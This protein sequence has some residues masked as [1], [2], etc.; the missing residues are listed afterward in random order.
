MEER[1]HTVKRDDAVVVE[2]GL[3]DQIAQ[4]R[5]AGVQAELAHDQAKLGRGDVAWEGAPQVRNTSG[6]GSGQFTHHR[7][8][9]PAGG[10]QPQAT[11]LAGDSTPL[12]AIG[13]ALSGTLAPR[14]C[15]QLAV[16]ACRD[17][18]SWSRDAENAEKTGRTKISNTSLYR[19]IWSGVSADLAS[20]EACRHSPDR[21]APSAL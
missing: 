19:A 5:V 12:A 9:C 2:V 21:G 17:R 7:H 20:L 3:G 14:G 13:T 10:A 6:R 15:M 16:A 1:R 8:P 4:L 18:G 11:L